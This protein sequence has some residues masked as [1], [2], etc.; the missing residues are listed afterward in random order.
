VLEGEGGTGWPAETIGVT[1]RVG[2][3]ISRSGCRN[4]QRAIA[5]RA[6]PA[7]RA[8]TRPTLAA[9]IGSGPTSAKRPQ[10]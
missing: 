10:A 6:R 1:G 8:C 2:L 7:A 3:V 4:G 5:R 9:R